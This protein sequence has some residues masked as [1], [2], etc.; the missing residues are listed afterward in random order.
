MPNK[1][2]RK[3]ENSHKLF[4]EYI[5]EIV[6]M[7]M[8]CCKVACHTFLSR[9]GFHFFSCAR[10]DYGPKILFVQFI[11]LKKYLKVKFL[12]GFKCVYV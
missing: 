9:Y 8:T 5:F 7:I 2:E 11:R 10:Y 3:H 12:S 6:S 4:Y 1:R